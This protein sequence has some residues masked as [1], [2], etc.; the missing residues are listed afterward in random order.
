MVWLGSRLG[1]RL[2]I[3]LGLWIVLGLQGLVEARVTVKDLGLG[4]Y[5]AIGS[6]PKSE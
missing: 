5:F 2:G 1:L 4:L 6:A 3:G